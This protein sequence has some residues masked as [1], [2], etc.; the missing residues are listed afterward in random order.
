VL[1]PT[2]T[3]LGLAA[4]ALAG[5]VAV[6]AYA[7]PGIGCGA[8]YAL[9]QLGATV[10]IATPDESGSEAEKFIR[11]REGHVLYRPVDLTDERQV[12]GFARIVMEHAGRPALLVNAMAVSP[13]AAIADMTTAAWDDAIAL[14]LRA[15][16]LTCRAFLPGM[17]A[18]GRGAIVNVVPRYGL[19]YLSAHAAA[20]QGLLGFTQAL[21]TEAGDRGVHVSALTLGLVDGEATR[22]TARLLAPLLGLASEQLV[23]AGLTAERA[24]A[25]LAY[26]AVH[27]ADYRGQVA[28]VRAILEHASLRP[29]PGEHVP[30]HEAPAPASAARTAAA[31]EAKGLAQGLVR[32]VTQVDAEFGRLPEPG[33]T[34]AHRRFREMAVLDTVEWLRMLADLIGH[35]AQVETVGANAVA[36]LRAEHRELAEYLQGLQTYFGA[37]PQR[38]AAS[39]EGDLA[40]AEQRRAAVR[41]LI[42]A[43]H[44]VEA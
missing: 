22:V 10:A 34:I 28:D 17:L 7:G 1:E 40:T 31:R 4:E 43:L 24:G 37:G 25:A 32:A 8:A 29:Q 13:V 27:A 14:D 9:A 42:D 19:A 39:T 26:L 18:A 44:R 35:L 16:F 3:S 11:G 36:A 30:P 12:A 23:D 41:A 2:L 38:P 33:R 15:P 21:A 20:G 6:V 5:E